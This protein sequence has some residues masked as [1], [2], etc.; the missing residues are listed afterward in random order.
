VDEPHDSE[1]AEAQRIVIRV[2]D[3]MVWV[4][5]P[6][7]LVALLASVL[8]TAQGWSTPGRVHTILLVLA[9]ALLLLRRRLPGPVVL[10]ALAG[11][12][13]ANGL[14][15]LLL[16]GLASLGLM[17]LGCSA[18]F[19]AV[20][21]GTRAGIWSLVML[22]VGAAAI[23]IAGQLGQLPV[24]PGAGPYLRST[25]AWIAQG[26][27]FALYTAVIV[28]CVSAVQ[29]GLACQARRLRQEIESRELVEQELRQRE[30]RYRLLAENMT[31][32]LFIQD[33]DL[34]PMYISP[35]LEVLLGY[36][37]EEAMTLRPK[38]YL[39]PASQE[40]MERLYQ[41]FLESGERP[42]LMEFEYV[43]KDGTTFW[44]ELRVAILHDEQG[45]PVGSQGILRDV[46]E[47]KVMERDKVELEA[48]LR[49][50]E[51]LRAIGELAG[52]VAHDF[53]NQLTG[54]QGS[55]E[56]LG[57]E[58]AQRDDLQPYL[59]LILTS[60]GRA[61]DLTAKLMAFA[62]RGQYRSEPTD[63]E[64]MVDEVVGIIEPSSDRSIV[65]V[66]ER[67]SS[68]AVVMGDPT[69]LQNAVLNVA[70][71]ARDA[72]P[73]GGELRLEC[74]VVDRERPSTF[75]TG[76]RLES[77]RHVCLVVSD[78][79]VGISEAVRSRLFEPFFTT[80]R[81]G[82]GTGMGLAATYGTVKA[83]GGAIDVLSQEGQGTRFAIYLPWVDR[84]LQRERQ[85]PQPLPRGSGT[86][87][88][89]DDE[90]A[91]QSTIST[92]LRRLGYQVISCGNGQEAL[93]CYREAVEPVD[94]VLLDMILPDNSG[95]EVFTALRQ[96]NPG[97]RILL[98]SG[99]GMELE[100]RDLLQWEHV[101]YLQ[102]PFTLQALARAVKDLAQES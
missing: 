9:A 41:Q 38:D 75:S 74:R 76:M 50:S 32:V 66:R 93:R 40:R 22:V 29:R 81:V 56:L 63:M 67:S 26:T 7:G 61:A 79:G 89:V 31:D 49:Q 35:S 68:P 96:L 87:L 92:T 27:G 1:H 25:Q 43:R 12:L 14:A 20:G 13:V 97:A 4:V 57:M 16:A 82:R 85:E 69:Q 23:G 39:T 52:G 58:L 72:M 30:E 102:K 17:I 100:T 51:K 45:R 101:A 48:Q 33:M 94:I 3:G 47:R 98:C 28:V 59:E 36:T 46:T 95:K 90:P 18:V 5:L 77:G 62:R 83:H 71:N 42:P 37:L 60:T 99:H 91:V 70:L 44:G 88:V 54:I 64:Q 65:I 78:T 11:V 53:N 80:K 84:E 34:R 24:L 15:N 21:F 2:L 73:R 8:R 86:V 55:A 6:L 19:I 10:W